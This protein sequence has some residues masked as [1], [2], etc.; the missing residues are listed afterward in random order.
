LATPT[1]G[2]ADP[3]TGAAQDASAAGMPVSPSSPA[4]PCARSGRATLEWATRW[5]GHP[6]NAAPSLFGGL[7]AVA[8]DDAGRPVAASLPISDAI[9]FAFAAPGRELDTPSARTVLPAQV[10]HACAVRAVGR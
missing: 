6:D 7:V 9:G 8:R 3:A 2:G 5:E 4:A 1:T 10:P